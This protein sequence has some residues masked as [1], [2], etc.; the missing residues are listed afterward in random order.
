MF[1]ANENLVKIL[2]SNG[3]I[4]T[5]SGVDKTKGKRTFKL[6]KNS[7]K[8]IHFDNINIRVL[9]SN[10]GFESKSV[11]SEEDL[12]AILLY[13][14]LSSSDFKELNS[15]NILEFNEA[16]ERIKSLRRE[17]LRLQATDGNLLRRVKLERI[18]ELYDSF[19]FN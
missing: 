14:K 11:L 3:F 9:N 13:F 16:N 17:Y 5:T 15:D 7:K 12:K 19:K 1:E 18:I 10:K 4:D 8:K 2:L 6:L